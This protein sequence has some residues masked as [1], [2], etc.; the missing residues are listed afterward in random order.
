MKDK[1]Y[2]V[3]GLGVFGSTVATTLSEYGCEV[4][5]VD[6]DPTCVERIADKITK[7]AV[8]DITNQ[9]ELQELGV[10]DFD[11]A[12]IGIGDHFE[13][14]ILATMIVKEMGVPYLVVKARN[15][16]NMRILEKI[17][18]DRVIRV[19]KEIGDRLAKS[20]VHK[21]IIDMIEIDDENSIVEI[22][23]L[24]SWV[25]KTLGDVNVRSLYQMN[26]LGVKIHGA[27]KLTLNIG[28]DYV[29]NSDDAFLVL[30]KTSVVDRFDTN[31]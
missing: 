15:K 8:A 16:Q 4:L 11:V 30:G 29:I 10:G 24:P 21:N 13:Q 7:A 9:Q 25:G 22:K 2:V 18:A 28:A 31:F 19:E 3:L 1:Q 23:P 27:K 20:L 26:I 5:G 17:G 12:I 14:A 6:I